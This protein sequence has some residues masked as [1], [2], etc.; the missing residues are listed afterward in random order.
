MNIRLIKVL[1][2]AGLLP[3]AA[4]AIGHLAGLPMAQVGVVYG[5]LILSFLGGIQWGSGLRG[6]VDQS[7]PTHRIAVSVVPSLIGFTAL[8]LPPFA[9]FILLGG[10]GGQWVY[11]RR[12]AD[13]V[14]WPEWFLQL[15][16]HLSLGAMIGLALLLVP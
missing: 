8:L 7:D 2:Y 13:S 1:G 9:V 14:D 10:F 4:A 5:A 3:F 11:D 16:G 12:H 6:H 15:R